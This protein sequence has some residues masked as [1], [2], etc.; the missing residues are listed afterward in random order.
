MSGGSFSYLYQVERND[1]VISGLEEMAEVL[2]GLGATAAAE[3]FTDIVALFNE[4]EKALGDPWSDS[5]VRNL[6]H[7]VEWYCSSDCGPDQ[8]LEAAAKVV[9]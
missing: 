8:V 3:R 1:R 6:M 9:R 7:A 5:P 4:A 2:R